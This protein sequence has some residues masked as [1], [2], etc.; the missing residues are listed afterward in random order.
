MSRFLILSLIDLHP[1]FLSAIA[2]PNRNLTINFLLFSLRLFLKRNVKLWI[3]LP[4]YISSFFEIIALD[5]V[6]LYFIGHQVEH[7]IDFV[8]AQAV[9]Y[10]LHFPLALLLDELDGLVPVNFDHLDLLL[11][12]GVTDN[13]HFL[14]VQSHSHKEADSVD[15]PHTAHFNRVTS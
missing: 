12:L 13:L 10:L 7:F 11:V 15:D 14:L 3:L 9:K 1:V 8:I 2:D 4:L 5:V 6:Y